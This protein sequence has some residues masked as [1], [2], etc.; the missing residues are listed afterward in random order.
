[1]VECIPRRERVVV[2]ADV[3]KHAGDEEVILYVSKNLEG[4]MMV[5]FAK[6]L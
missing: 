5:D 4:Q 6:R 1:M 2:G 3:N